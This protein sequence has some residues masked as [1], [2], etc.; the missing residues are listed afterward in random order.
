MPN[1]CSNYLIITGESKKIAKIK[2]I[3]TAAQAD[4]PDAGL[5]E[6]L[7]GKKPGLT[8]EEIDN[9]AWYEANTSYYG[10]KRLPI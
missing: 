4:T 8:Q 6:T 1:W 10:T 5:F 2:R 9:G 3:I 7:I